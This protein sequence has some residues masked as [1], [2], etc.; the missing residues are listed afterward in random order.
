MMLEELEAI[1]RDGI[2]P[3][4]LERIKQEQ[5]ERREASVQQDGFWLAALGGLYRHGEDP[6]KILAFPELVA[7]IT[8]QQI[9]EAARHYIDLD[10][11]VLGLLYPKSWAESTED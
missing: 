5:L 2:A 10:R 9:D 11:Y 1:R 8:P 4:Y 6:R 7:A 3:A